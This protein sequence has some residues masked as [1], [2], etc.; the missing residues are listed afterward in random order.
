MQTTFVGLQLPTQ[1]NPTGVTVGCIEPGAPTASTSNAGYS[2]TAPCLISPSRSV[3][4]IGA[5]ASG[6]CTLTARRTR[7]FEV[8]QSGL[9]LQNLI[10]TGGEGPLDYGGNYYQYQISG[11]YTIQQLHGGGSVLADGGSVLAAD[12]C[13]FSGNIG[14]QPGG[15]A[16]A[17]LAMFPQSVTVTNSNFSGNTAYSGAG[18]AIYT[19]G[20]LILA[21]TT[22]ASNTATTGGAVSAMLGVSA[23]NCTFSLNTA[24]GNG[25]AVAVPPVSATNIGIVSF[26]RPALID[27]WLA[28]PRTQ[29]DSAFNASVFAQNSASALGGAV[30]APT[31]SLVGLAGCTFQFNSAYLAGGALAGD[32]VSDVGSTFFSNDISQGGLPDACSSAGGGALAVIGS[33]GLRLSG[34]VF[35]QNQGATQGGAILAAYSSPFSTIS[36]GLSLAAPVYAPVVLTNVVFT[37]NRVASGGGGAMVLSDLNATLLNVTC[38]NNQAGGVGGCLNALQ[39]GGLQIS[40]GSVFSANAAASGG[41]IGLSCGV[42]CAATAWACGVGVGPAVVVSISQSTFDSNSATSQG[43]GIYVRGGGLALN[44]VTFTYNSATNGIVG[45]GGGLFMA[46]YWSG[47]PST[48]LPLAGSGLTLVNTSFAHNFAFGATASS[49]PSELYS[50]TS[51]PGAGGG[52]FFSSTYQTTPVT[53]SGGSSWVSN[54]ANTGAGAYIYGSTMLSLAGASFTGN[55]AYGTGGTGGALALANPT[56]LVPPTYLTAVLSACN[57]S[58]NAAT[59]LGGA[60]ATTA[61]VAFNAYGCSFVNNTAANGAAFALSTPQGLSRIALVNTTT[62]GNTAGTAGGLF[63]TDATNATLAPVTTCSPVNCSGNAA[64]NGANTLVTS[65]FRFTCSLNATGT[66]VKSGQALPV[67]GISLYDALGNLVLEAPDVVA[68]L[69]TNNNNLAGTTAAQYRNGSATFLALVLTGLPNTTATLTY[70]LSSASLPAI[71]GQSGSV[72]VGLSQCGA[73]EAFDG[74]QLKCVCAAGTSL[75]YTT[76]TCQLCPQGQYAPSTGSA[77]C[78]IN[79]PGYYSSADRTKQIACP[80]GTFLNGTSLACSPCAAGTFTS[81]VGQTTC[82]VNPAG[83][84]SS[85]QTTLASSLSLAGVAAA[86]FGG[87]QYGSLSTAIFAAAN[88][89]GSTNLTLTSITDVA[90][91]RRLSATKLQVNY[92][93]TATGTSSSAA[94]TSAISTRLNSSA[95]FA[96]AVATSLARS[97]DPVL[98]ALPA[99]AITAAVPVATTVYLQAEPC[100]AGTYLNAVNQTCD[101]CAVGTVAPSAS[102]VTCTV[103]AARTAW[104]NAA[105]ACLSLIHISEPTR[106]M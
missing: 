1:S 37:N 21:N 64:P 63:Y 50:G 105:A 8:Y 87:R 66:V 14:Q 28:G 103:C 84:V 43:G 9:R 35:N 57:F 59:T 39:L 62:L 100:A 34:T 71:N 18:G 15:G 36:N 102:S 67:F 20:G 44:S 47:N 42:A 73:T 29:P 11:V 91:R 97:G 6:P 52:L 12:S 16:L 38:A 88:I 92:T 61:T 3:T 78:L 53:A 2:S 72:T 30:Y 54:M 81:L 90:A 75:N 10:L 46:E 83:E 45:Q 99:T 48:P 58:A 79:T 101:P 96:A 104:L 41:A 60:V 93:L 5:C 25:G 77:S 22:F 51:A 4:I 89:S 13:T 31:G 95:S 23:S 56:I 98:S 76:S 68:T 69:N 27:R 80:V 70:T 106:L 74:T 24:Q 40:G 32:G 17:S 82:Q 94:L 19:R 65:P 49:F 86:S 33:R 26:F 85:P 55:S 7:H